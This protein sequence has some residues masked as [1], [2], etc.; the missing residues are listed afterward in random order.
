M[1]YNI[2]LFY[3]IFSR[4]FP[5]IYNNIYDISNTKNIFLKK[6]NN[7][8]L[9]YIRDFC[10][11][12]SQGNYLTIIYIY[13]NN[14]LK[15]ELYDIL[16]LILFNILYTTTISFWYINYKNF[17]N[18]NNYI[19]KIIYILNHGPLLIYYMTKIP[20]N[21]HSFNLINYLLGN[22]YLLFWYI[23]IWYPWKYI[24]N[25]TLYDILYIDNNFKNFI[26]ILKILIIY[27]SSCIFIYLYLNLDILMRLIF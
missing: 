12:T 26:S 15:K 8:Y 7:I 25:D 3:T 27:Y 5:T 22:L 23:F 4:L 6:C 10:M 20:E 21:I 11:L 1:N 2:I 14:Y 24:T 19:L 18:T 13:Y 17:Y 9:Y 16:F